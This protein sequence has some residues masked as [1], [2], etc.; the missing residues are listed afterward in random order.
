MKKYFELI[1][2]LIFLSGLGSCRFIKVPEV[3]AIFPN[4]GA[5][6]TQVEISGKNFGDINKNK[7]NLYFGG[8]TTPRSDIISWSQD[9]IIAIVPKDAVTGKV[10]VE[11]NGIK[12]KD[13]VVFTVLSFSPI[14]IPASAGI[15]LKDGS[16]RFLRA[17]LQKGF[18]IDSNKIIS[19]TFNGEKVNIGKILSVKNSSYFLASGWIEEGDNTK[20]LLFGWENFKNAITIPV[21]TDGLINDAVMKDDTIYLLDIQAREIEELDPKAWEIT[22]KISI[23][24]DIPFSHPFRIFYSDAVSSF[25]IFTKPIFDTQNGEL[26]YYDPTF[27]LENS[28]ILP[29]VNLYEIFALKTRY[30]LTGLQDSRS[31]FYSISITDPGLVD[32]RIIALNQKTIRAEGFALAPSQEGVIASD[33]E[34]SNLVLAPFALKA[35]EKYILNNYY[36]KPLTD[37]TI[38]R[39]VQ[40]LNYVFVKTKKSTLTIVD[41]SISAIYGNFSFPH[42]IEDIAVGIAAKEE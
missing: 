12:S 5:V 34:D 42:E 36:N 6:G 23:I 3:Y 4:R 39:S 21:I 40:G 38:I 15:L 20:Y 19:L 7:V 18:Y 41:T 28:V 1:V 37:P 33:P 2:I 16:I 31:I 24:N 32:S 26:L 27:K 11:V 9:K 14:N 30:I 17:D 35:P 10:V 22:S 29:H 13:N 8:V 25:I